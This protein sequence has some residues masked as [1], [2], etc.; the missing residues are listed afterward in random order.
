MKLIMKTISAIA[1][2]LCLTTTSFADDV[3]F[4]V[5]DD[6]NTFIQ[7]TI[8]NMFPTD[9]GSTSI[10]L[11]P[12]QDGFLLLWSDANLPIDPTTG[13]GDVINNDSFGFNVGVASTTASIVAGTG[14]GES[15]DFSA[16]DILNPVVN[17]GPNAGGQRWFTTSLAINSFVALGDNSAAVDGNNS[18]VGP[19]T[20]DFDPFFDPSRNAFLLGIARFNTGTATSGFTELTPIINPTSSLDGSERVAGVTIGVPEPTSAAFLA[21]GLVGFVSRRRR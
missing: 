6:V 9:T 15:G 2:V 21:I 8:L 4:T 18:G 16:F 3:F 1:I 17:G 10:Q 5:T 19:V 14:P 12:G 13:T 7:A 20:Q 11:D